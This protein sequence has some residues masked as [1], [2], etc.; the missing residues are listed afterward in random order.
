MGKGA[1]RETAFQIDGVESCEDLGDVLNMFFFSLGVDETV[2]NEGDDKFI[3]VGLQH[4]VDEPHK[5]AGGIGE[6]HWEDG[7][8]VTSIPGLEGREVH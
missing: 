1:L 3:Q 6:T 7:E 5:G 2:I 4:I 8:L